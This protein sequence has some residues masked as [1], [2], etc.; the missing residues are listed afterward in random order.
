MTKIKLMN[1]V[2]ARP[3]FIKAAAIQHQLAQYPNLEEIFVHTGQHYDVQMSDVFFEEFGL[4]KPQYQLN[5]HDSLEEENI[6][7]IQQKLIPIIQEVKPDCIVVYGDTYSTYAAALAA[8]RCKV[9]LVHIEAGLRSFDLTMPEERYRIGTDQI[10]D[11]LFCPSENA[12]KNLQKENNPHLEN[13]FIVGDIMKDCFRTYLQK[14]SNKDIKLMNPPYILV[15][16]HRQSNVDNKDN[17]KSILKALDS[18]HQEISVVFP[19]HPRS[20][21]MMKHY[22][23]QTAIQV[24]NPVGYNEMMSL[25]INSKMV[26]TDSGGLQKEAY[27][28]GKPSLILREQ[29]EWVELVDKGYSQLAGHDTSHI[30]SAFKRFNEVK[31][32]IDTDLLYGDGYTARMIVEKIQTY[33]N[34]HEI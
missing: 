26:I 34:K 5:V 20:Q 24:I 16:L 7:N 30:Y 31:K 11:L 12:L 17:F 8:Q 19:A 13:T 1:I 18:I 15:T 10:A 21:K 22:N 23:L 29:T 6:I 14:G 25:L 28:A 4:K 27:Y 32:I 2:G 3:Q 33:M 9:L